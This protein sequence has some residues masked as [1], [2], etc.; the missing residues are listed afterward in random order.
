MNG[1]NIKSQL[2]AITFSVHNG[3]VI[4]HNYLLNTAGSHVYNQLS[5][6]LWF[7][8][9]PAFCHETENSYIKRYQ[10]CNKRKSFLCSTGYSDIYLCNSVLSYR[11]ILWRRLSYF[12]RSVCSV[13]QN[14]K[15]LMNDEHVRIWQNAWP[16]TP[17]WRGKPRHISHV[18]N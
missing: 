1:T 6:Y 4:A 10:V 8:R 12:L 13:K 17:M 18:D 7:T 14:W 15:M 2:S 3:T 11:P 9:A 16:K 5:E